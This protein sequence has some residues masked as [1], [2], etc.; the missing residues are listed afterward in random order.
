[1]GPLAVSANHRFFVDESGAPF[2]WLAD[3]A[4]SLPI[5]LDRAETIEYLDTRAE[6]GYNV[7]Q[8]VAI[9]PQAGGPGPNR[10][11][12]QPVRRRPGRLARHRGLRPRRTLSV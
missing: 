3:T 1:M 11:G 8:T 9:F 12:R 6:Q 2:F 10:Y 5:N 7:I 4:W